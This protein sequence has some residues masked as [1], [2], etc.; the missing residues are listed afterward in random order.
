MVGEDPIALAARLAAAK[1]Q[2]AAR[3]VPDAF[4]IGSDQV[5]AVDGQVL[6]KPGTPERACAQLAMLSGRIHELIT[7]VHVVAPT[8]EQA[9]DVMIHEMAM[10][11]LS[12]G[13]IERYVAA[14]EPLDCAGSYKIEARGIALFRSLR[15]DDYTSIIGLPLTLVRRLLDDL[16]FDWSDD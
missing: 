11:T 6:S 5:I 2:V 10:R 3:E 15:G 7:A 9:C 13:E 8:G 16:G 14:D 12:A 4:I 1:A